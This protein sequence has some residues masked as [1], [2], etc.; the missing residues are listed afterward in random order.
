MII[1]PC[2]K[3]HD[4]P[5]FLRLTAPKKDKLNG[6][7][8]ANTIR[9]SVLDA[10]IEEIRAMADAGMLFHKIAEKYGVSRSVI[11]KYIYENGI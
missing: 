7:R 9:G 3:E 2:A 10:H 11:E 4:A 5:A 8:Y 1:A 6:M